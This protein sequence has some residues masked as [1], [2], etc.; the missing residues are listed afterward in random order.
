MIEQIPIE[1]GSGLLLRKLREQARTYDSAAWTGR[2]GWKG[3]PLVDIWRRGLRGLAWPGYECQQCV[4]QEYGQGC[5]CA[6]NGASSPGEGPEWW[7]VQ[8]RMLFK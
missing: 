1:H 7:R 8:L 3:S 5:W 2:P 6:Y 4:G